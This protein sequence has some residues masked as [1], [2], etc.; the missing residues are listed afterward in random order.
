LELVAKVED[1]ENVSLE[2]ILKANVQDLPSFSFFCCCSW[3]S[4]GF[5]SSLG[6]S[7]SPSS[8]PDPFPAFFALAAFGFAFDSFFFPSVVAGVF[9]VESFN[10]VAVLGVFAG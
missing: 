4:R 3:G 8:L 2:S 6:V 1:C 7:A 5:S 10:L 9:G